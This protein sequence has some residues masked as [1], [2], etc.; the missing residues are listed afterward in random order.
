M[1]SLAIFNNA[2]EHKL[3]ALPFIKFLQETNLKR[4]KYAASISK[5]I[6]LASF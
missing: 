4:N 5:E 1:N 6:S 2:V 3:M